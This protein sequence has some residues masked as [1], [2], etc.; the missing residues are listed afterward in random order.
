[1]RSPAGLL[2]AFVAAAALAGCAADIESA[3]A[4][5]TTVASPATTGATVPSS[6]P[7]AAVAETLRFTTRT[8]DGGTFDGATLA[9]RPAV[10]WFWAAWCPRCRAAAPDVAAVQREYAGKVSV[11]GVAGLR[12]GQDA[13]R[14]FVADRGIGG[15]P[16]LAD[17]DGVLWRRFGVTTQEYYVI[18]DARGM[19]VH[20]GALSTQDLRRRVD[21]LVG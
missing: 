9:G 10:L 12:S 21:A 3:Q 5:A 18:L 14:R 13:M 20:Q 4:P 11:I 16:N 15:F 1:V 2:A 17:D 19:V 7:A 6:T 8:V